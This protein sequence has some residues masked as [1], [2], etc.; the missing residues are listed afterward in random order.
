MK[1]NSKNIR[2]AAR[3]ENCSLQIAGICN[4]DPE[5]TVFAHLSD[6][7]NGMGTKSDDLSGCFSCSAC[8]NCIDGRGGIGEL[9]Y[10]EFYM[11]RAMVRTWRRLFELG[12][13]TIKGMN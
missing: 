2:D 12:I 11:R 6:E 4:Y 3:G 13:L 7:S 5:T 8:H 1:I 9:D 10:K